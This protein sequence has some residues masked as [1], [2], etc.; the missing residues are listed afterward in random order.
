MQFY[1]NQ[2]HHQQIVNSGHHRGWGSHTWRIIL[3]FT[4][5]STCSCYSWWDTGSSQSSSQDINTGNNNNNN[6]NKESKQ[7]CRNQENRPRVFTPHCS[8]V[9]LAPGDSLSCVIIVLAAIEPFDDSF[10]CGGNY[11]L[12]VVM[13]N[14]NLVWCLSFNYFYN[15][16]INNLI[17]F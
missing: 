12:I 9:S 6:N 14:F 13:A 15:D 17:A 2:P 7:V 10:R 16:V 3:T 8:C 11:I 4:T 1:G 5:V